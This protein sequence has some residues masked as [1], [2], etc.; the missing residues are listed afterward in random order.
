[1]TYNQDFMGVGATI[2]GVSPVTSHQWPGGQWPVSVCRK[3][4]GCARETQHD[5]STDY[6][7]T[8]ERVHK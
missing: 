4:N 5:N 1:M 7:Q 2:I 8:G 3:S 6:R